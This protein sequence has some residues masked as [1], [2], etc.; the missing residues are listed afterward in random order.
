MILHWNSGYNVAL[1][2]NYECR[3]ID[4]RATG[5]SSTDLMGMEREENVIWG[6][7]E[8]EK[9]EGGRGEERDGTEKGR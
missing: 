9:R 5:K 6:K 2:L 3:D 1:L 4:P 8:R 7:M